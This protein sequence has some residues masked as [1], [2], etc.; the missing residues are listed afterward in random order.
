[1]HSLAA[2]IFTHPYG[3]FGVIWF[4]FSWAGILIYPLIDIKSFYSKPR[5]AKEQTAYIRRQ[6][7]NGIRRYCRLALESGIPQEDVLEIVQ[8][9]II[10][11]VHES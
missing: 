10:R 7:R 6:Y 9:E 2:D 1:M 4:W 3:I 5:L 8:Q 11:D